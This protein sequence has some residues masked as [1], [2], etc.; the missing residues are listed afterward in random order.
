MGV[1]KKI[2][3]VHQN[4][5]AQY[6]HLANYFADNKDFEVHTLSITK[7]EDDRMENHHYTP[8]SSSTPNINQFSIE[9]ETKMIR[10]E[11]VA[12]KA[13]ALKKNNFNPDLILGH[14]GWGE[15]IFLKEIWPD[16]PLISYVEFY[17]KTRDCDI[18]FDI[19]L[20]K[21][22]KGD[23]DRFLNFTRLKLMAR[24]SYF[25]QSYLI[26]DYLVCPTEFQKDQL[27]D[28][29]RDKIDIIHDG[30]DTNKLKPEEDVSFKVNDVTLTN[31]DNVISYIS[32]SLDPYRGFHIFIKSIPGI[33]EKNPEANILIVGNPDTPGYGSPL[34]EGRFKE[35]FYSRIEGKIDTSRVHFLGFLK[36]ED[37][38]KVLKITTVHTYLTYPFILSWSMLEAMSCG[39][40]IVG[41]NTGPVTEVIK[42]N[43]NGIIV[44][45]FDHKAIVENIT[46]ILKNRDKYT[47]IKENAR[48]TIL[49]NYDLEKIC[50]P[51]HLK[52]IDKAIR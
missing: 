12:V 42:N 6:K 28:I 7:Y 29:F 17:Y 39:A 3:F 41:S 27:P 22:V 25:S 13:L 34:K 35:Y 43:E 8:Q 18:D 31:K 1:K 9:F 26:S 23:V 45:F 10:A 11:S 21:E 49:N 2:L 24:N 37:Y 14:P 52:L 16:C 19:D 15:T 48:K 4:F 40:L 50:L 32:R 33:L 5:P 30:I 51:R 36:Y 20:L 46:N 38:L 47:K 44:D